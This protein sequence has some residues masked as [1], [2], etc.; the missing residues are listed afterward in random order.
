M[1]ASDINLEQSLKFDPEHGLL[2]FGPQRMVIMSAN[3][4]FRLSALIIDI[5]GVETARVFIPRF[6]EAAGRDDAKLLKEQ[7]SPD[8]DVDWLAMG[9]TI[10]AWEGLVKPS[11]DALEMDREANKFFLQGKWENS[12]MAQEYLNVFGP[13]TEPVCWLLSGYATG[14]CSEVFGQP[15]LCK[16]TMCVAKGDPYCQFT[17]KSKSEWMADW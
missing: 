11:V 15:L 1:K 9:P 2:T 17:V 13:S 10:H 7:L 14:Y 16:E 3:A 12:F 5:G 4:L 8:T 6:G